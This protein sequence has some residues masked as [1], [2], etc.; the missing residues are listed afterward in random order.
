MKGLVTGAVPEREL[1]RKN[2]AQKFCVYKQMLQHC[3][4]K[5]KCLPS[6]TVFDMLLSSKRKIN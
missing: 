1:E 3:S 5:E 2:Q 6:C 4:T